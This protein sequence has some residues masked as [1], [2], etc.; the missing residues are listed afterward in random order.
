MPIPIGKQIKFLREAAGLSQFGLSKLINVHPATIS[1]WETGNREPD[2]AM[3]HT[4]A[5]YF[6]VTVDFLMGE[7]EA[8]SAADGLPTEVAVSFRKIDWSKLSQEDR[9]VVNAVI[10]SVTEK[11]ANRNKEEE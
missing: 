7:Q 8:M 6:N 4:I 11:Y 3:V 1:L 10:K 5:K 9:I 2:L